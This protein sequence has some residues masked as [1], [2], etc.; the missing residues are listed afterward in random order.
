MRQQKLGFVCPGDKNSKGHPEF[1]GSQPSVQGHRCPCWYWKMF[2]KPKSITR[3]ANG[4]NDM[5]MIH[6][7]NH[8][9]LY[10]ATLP[11]SRATHAVIRSTV[12][13][14]RNRKI[15]I[16]SLKQ[17]RMDSR[18]L[19]LDWTCH[20][21]QVTLNPLS[22][23]IMLKQFTTASTT[24]FNNTVARELFPTSQQAIKSQ[25]VSKAA[26]KTL[27]TKD[28]LLSLPWTVHRS[29]RRFPRSDCSINTQRWKSS[30]ESDRF[31]TRVPEFVCHCCE[32]RYVSCAG[33]LYVYIGVSGLEP[34]C[35]LPMCFCQVCPYGILWDRSRGLSLWLGQAQS[36][37][38]LLSVLTC[39]V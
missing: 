29:H 28:L 18:H 14:L 5:Y 36:K 8:V 37:A 17:L 21:K 22:L 6:V 20:H 39:S 35:S 34:A 32:C 25:R 2:N 12:S 4:L 15:G 30:I 26:V 19:K 7:E 13:E 38:K 11:A 33:E 10:F 1:H 9:T 16:W 3:L 27:V 24:S 23:Q 31:S